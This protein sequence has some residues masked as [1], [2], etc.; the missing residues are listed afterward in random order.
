MGL[1]LLVVI[2]RLRK[3]DEAARFWVRVLGINFAIG[4][5]TGIPAC[6][7]GWPGGELAFRSRFYTRPM[8]TAR[9]AA[10]PGSSSLTN[11][12]LDRGPS[13]TVTPGR[14]SSAA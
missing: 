12:A 4:V 5:V 7:S 1:A 14:R 11:P 10:R 13:V 8:S 6:A 2:F 9:C 3:E